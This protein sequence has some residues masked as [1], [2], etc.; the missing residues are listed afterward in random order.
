MAHGGIPVVIDSSG[1]LGT[2]S[3]SRRV[4]TD[5]RDMPD[6]TATL[7]RLRP[8][9]FR[10]I[11]QGENA[12]LQYGLIAEEVRDVAPDLVAHNAGGEVETVY[13][14]KVNAMLLKVVQEQ[15]R[16]I[17]ELKKEMAELRE[18]RK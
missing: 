7:M 2:V 16:A 18:Q 12:P 6:A 8:V 3:S 9:E 4:K 17:E 11:A 10:Y 5:I 15:Q 13:Y 1:Q 14:D